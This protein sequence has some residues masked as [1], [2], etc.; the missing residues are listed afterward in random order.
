[1]Q[2][3]SIKTNRSDTYLKCYGDLKI[4]NKSLKQIDWFKV[5]PQIVSFTLLYFTVPNDDQETASNVIIDSIFSTGIINNGMVQNLIIRIYY[6]AKILFTGIVD[7]EQSDYLEIE[8]IALI[9]CYDSL[10]M[11]SFLRDDDYQIINNEISSTLLASYLQSAINEYGIN[12]F[13][14][15][16]QYNLVDYT[17]PN[18]VY[19]LLN[20]L[21]G[22]GNGWL[23]DIYDIIF[24]PTA[25]IL[26]TP[27]NSDSA[28]F[29]F[30]FIHIKCYPGYYD[31][32]FSDVAI[33]AVLFRIDGLTFSEKYR[34]YRHK[35]FGDNPNINKPASVSNWRQEDRDAI[36]DIIG[37]NL[38]DYLDAGILPGNY[39][40]LYDIEDTFSFNG[41]DYQIIIPAS[42][43]TNY[44]LEVTGNPFSNSHVFGDYLET[45]YSEE[46][47]TNIIDVMKMML[48]VNNM[49]CFADNTGIIILKAYKG[50]T[51]ITVLDD[52]DILNVKRNYI[53][54][55]VIDNIDGLD[56]DY[57]TWLVELNR[58][59][60]SNLNSITKSADIIKDG[61]ESI[62]IGDRITNSTY[63]LDLFIFKYDYNIDKSYFTVTGVSI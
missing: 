57:S 7:I 58:Y 22:L 21:A 59:Y 35:S 48:K 10:R 31:P 45:G 3:Y 6:G 26:P 16:N 43:L 32:N 41:L 40:F 62:R 33:E 51:T 38:Q 53:A 30:G 54:K 34:N 61:N 12:T 4:G 25:D 29:Y 52:D 49:I 24:V 27:E 8:K 63:S 55:Q 46:G 44:K 15:S 50:Y 14:V 19:I 37:I 47:K 23:S 13:T 28:T 9:T 39:P 60:A 1:M 5:E 36:Y 42:G 56:S 17:M 11:L 18:P 20:T 2:E